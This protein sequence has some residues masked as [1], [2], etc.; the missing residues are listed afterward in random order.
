[1]TT[2]IKYTADGKKVSVV[3]KLNNS[4]YIVQEIYVSG[5]S[6]IPAGENFVVRSLLDEPAVSWKE[7]HIADTEKNFERRQIELS[8]KSEKLSRDMRLAHQK[9]EA[10]IKALSE[11]LHEDQSAGPI[12]RIYDFLAGKITHLAV[13]GY[14]PSVV[15]ADDNFMF[16]IYDGRVDGVKLISIFGSGYKGAARLEYRINSY[17]DGSGSWETVAPCKSKEEA[18]AA[19]QAAYDEICESFIGSP[20]KHSRIWEWSK[21]PDLSTPESA[22]SIMREK[23]LAT[24]TKNIERKRKELEKE[25]EALA[26]AKEETSTQGGG[27]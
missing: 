27:E 12:Q 7:K 22:L 10:R 11:F 18:V 24:I 3:G 25:M 15:A 4:E 17:K 2:T 19:L 23:R 26:I 13:L 9:A 6:E 8:S 21:H 14:R 16:E 20:D 1:M 5:G